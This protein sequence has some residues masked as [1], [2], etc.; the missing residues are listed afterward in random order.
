MNYLNHFKFNPVICLNISTNKM[1]NTILLLKILKQEIPVFH[2]CRLF[3]SGNFQR[4]TLCG[5]FVTVYG[6]RF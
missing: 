6:P 2:S 5:S 4:Q 1:S 3:R